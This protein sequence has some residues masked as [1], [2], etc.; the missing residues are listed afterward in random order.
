MRGENRERFLLK[1]IGIGLVIGI[2]EWLGS[3]CSFFWGF[4][5]GKIFISLFGGR[6]LLFKKWIL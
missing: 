5:I 1:L 4:V 2:L 3:M 6:G